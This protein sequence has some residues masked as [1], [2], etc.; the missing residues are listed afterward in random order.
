MQTRK[1]AA[2]RNGDFLVQE[3]S[4]G[5]GCRPRPGD[6]GNSKDYADVLSATDECTGRGLR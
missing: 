5:L 6:G 4:F 3:Q 2:E 1:G